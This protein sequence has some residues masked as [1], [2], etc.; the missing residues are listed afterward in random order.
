MSYYYYYTCHY[1]DRVEEMDE[2]LR[3]TTLV[4]AMTLSKRICSPK[5]TSRTLDQASLEEFTQ[6]TAEMGTISPLING[7]FAFETSVPILM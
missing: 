4:A 7:R 6:T 1:Q 3:R 5:R 2:R